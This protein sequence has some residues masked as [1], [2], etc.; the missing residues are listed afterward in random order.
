M[1]EREFLKYIY[2]IDSFWQTGFFLL[3]KIHYICKQMDVI[4][5]FACLMQLDYILTHK[6]EGI[7]DFF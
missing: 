1:I 5:I 7:F 2:W 3:V 4:Y 6:T